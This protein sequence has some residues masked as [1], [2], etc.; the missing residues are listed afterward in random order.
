MD[1][2]QTYFRQHGA[3]NC[4]RMRRHLKNKAFK[5]SV[6]VEFADE[7]TANKVRWGDQKSGMEGS[8]KGLAAVNAHAN[9]VRQIQQA[10]C[11]ILC[12]V[13]WRVWGGRAQATWCDGGVWSS[14]VIRLAL[15]LLA[16]PGSWHDA[17]V[18]G[19]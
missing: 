18:R 2:L 12:W 14:P 3:V 7:E 4:V 15:L 10:A 1:Q 9:R 8:G 6:F 5:G 16:F 11:Y 19:R 17:R 13:V